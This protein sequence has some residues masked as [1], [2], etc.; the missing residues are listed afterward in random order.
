MIP[1]VLVLATNRDTK[2]RETAVTGDAGQY[3]LAAIPAGRY[4]LEVESPG[5]KTHRN[6]LTLNASDSQRFDIIMELG[7]ISEKVEVIGKKPAGLAARSVVPRRIRVGGNVVA[8][9]LVSKVAPTYPEIAQ[10]KGIEGPVLLEAVISTGGNILSL[11]AVT[12][13]DPDLAAAA[14]A[15]VQQWHY[16]PTLLNGQPVE[17]VTTITVEFRLK[18]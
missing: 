14:M 8:A 11:K 5:F 10:E 1:G 13:A 18:P 6:D 12:T 16:Q 2:A 3:S 9:Q 15:A 7:N 17:V 4:T